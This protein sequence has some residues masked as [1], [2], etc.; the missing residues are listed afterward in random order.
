VDVSA[1]RYMDKEMV[2]AMAQLDLLKEGAT[3][4]S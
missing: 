4:Y 3:G 1:T 2:E